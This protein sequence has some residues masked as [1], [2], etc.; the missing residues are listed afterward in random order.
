MNRLR[1]HS[2][3]L[4]VLGFFVVQIMALAWTTRGPYGVDFA[5]YF[6]ASRALGQGRNIYT[7]SEDDWQALAAEAQADVAP[8]YRYPPLIAG[9][10][11]PIAAQPFTAAL[12]IWRAFTVLALLLTS[13][14]LSQFFRQR[15]VDPLIFFGAAFFVPAITTLY[16]GQANTFVLAALAVFLLLD[17]RQRPWLAGIALAFSILIKPLSIALAAYFI[18]R[19]DWKRLAALLAGLMI[20]VV[21][22]VMVA[23]GQAQL[24]Y[25]RSFF[26][27]APINTAEIS[28]YPP[29]QSIFGFWIR[30]LTINEFST[31]HAVLLGQA[32]Q[33]SYLTAGG[34]AMLTA[35]LTWPRR[36]HTFA[37]GMGL[38][39]V[40]FSLIVPT[41][42][43]HHFTV[44]L[45]PLLLAWFAATQ[46][47]WRAALLA[48]YGLIGVQGLLWKSFIEHTLLLSLATYGLLI[49]YAALAVN[50]WAARR[51]PAHPG[52]RTTPRRD[53]Q[54]PTTG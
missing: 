33:L 44:D 20:G 18:W 26:A 6:L 31:A 48:A 9:V 23:G 49:I 15:W 45:I 10:L 52:R 34:L 17:Q 28:G 41:S 7:L 39:L 42:W 38:V 30:L 2:S 14:C 53:A 46:R 22:M 27:V 32:V 37:L 43:Y 16:A 4:T 51:N 11:R 50:L 8:P 29:N 3:A 19:R 13:L 12:F 1:R 21:V 54:G 5:A 47:S 24:D 40:T 35:Y 36:R 25:A